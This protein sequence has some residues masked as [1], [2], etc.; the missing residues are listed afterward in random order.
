MRGYATVGWGSWVLS[1]VQMKRGGTFSSTRNRWI[2]ACVSGT[3][4]RA[5]TSGGSSR[6]AVLWEIWEGTDGFRRTVC[7][8]SSSLTVCSS[9]TLPP[10]C[11]LCS[12][13]L[14]KAPSSTHILHTTTPSSPHL[15]WFTRAP[16]CT[17]MLAV[18]PCIRSFYINV[19][20]RRWSEAH[21]QVN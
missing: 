19:V 8:C 9:H 13:S 10:P 17:P 15:L 3:Q 11:L 2:W 7:L 1:Q 14:L 21:L 20:P 4:A 16:S 6:A 18:A 12:A 5:T